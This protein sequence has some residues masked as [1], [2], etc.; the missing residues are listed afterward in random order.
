MNIIPADYMDDKAEKRLQSMCGGKIAVW[1]VTNTVQVMTDVLPSLL[2]D[3]VYFVDSS[4]FKQGTSIQGKT[5]MPPD[6]IAEEGVETVILTL[7]TPT[8]LEIIDEIHK[9]YPSVTKIMYAGDLLE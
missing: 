4:K 8:V 1:P 9:K 7:T 2:T 5:I 3:N 6:V